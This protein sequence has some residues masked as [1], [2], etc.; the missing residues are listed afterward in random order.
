MSDEPPATA[1]YAPPHVDDVAGDITQDLHGGLRHAGLVVL[2]AIHVGLA[3]PGLL[4]GLDDYRHPWIPV[5]A[6][7]VLT[8]IVV[9]HA[10]LG[11]TGRAGS[12]V[13]TATALTAALAAAIAASSQLSPEHF[14]ANPHWSF[15]E[16]GWFGVLLLLGR[17][18]GLT[19][20]F[21]GGHLTVMLGL[22]TLTG[23]PS[24]PVAAG[25]AVSALAVCVFQVAT[26][27]MAGLL[28]TVA[29]TAAATTHEQERVRTDGEVSARVQEDQRARYGELRESVL[30]LLAGLADGSLDPADEAVRRRSAIEAAR[31]RRLF[32][33]RDHAADLLVHELRACIGVA[34]R[35][36]VDVQFAV[37]GASAPVPR[38]LCRALT[39]PA[40]AALAT[41]ERTARATVVRGGG[42][43]RVSVVTDAPDAEIPRQGA[44]GVEIRTLRRDGRLWTEA[45]YRLD[46][47]SLDGR[48]LDGRSLDGRSLHGQSSSSETRPS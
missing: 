16:L 7:G 14:F 27:V 33:E 24:R 29:A 3:L 31:L 41:A 35:K 12:A 13:W 43:I 37:R 40:L 8:L 26:A 21:I 45:T 10:L 48:S 28:R 20:L 39:E 30:P 34:E 4:A 44:H 5:T 15:L 42:M 11:R 25:M 32:A 1:P 46:G 47:Q 6:Y 36:G 2:T 23:L 17:P 18:L 22:L 19:L 9:G 38:P